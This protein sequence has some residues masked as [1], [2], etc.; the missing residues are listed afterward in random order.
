MKHGLATLAL[1]VL[2]GCSDTRPAEGE[3]LI[4]LR[5]WT[6]P[7]SGCVYYVWRQYQM[8]GIT[9]KLR[10]DGTPECPAAPR[11]SPDDI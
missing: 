10:S 3:G 6:D 7:S 5:E 2:A 1:G 9:A 11:L 4:A 8:G